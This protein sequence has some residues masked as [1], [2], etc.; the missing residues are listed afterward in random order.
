TPNPF[1]NATYMATRPFAILAF[2]W[3]IKLLPIYE[4][5]KV[6]IKDYVLFSVFLLLTTMTKPSF[7]IIMVGAAGLIMVYRM[8]RSRFKNFWPTR[9]LGVCFIPT[10]IDLLY[11]YSGVFVPTDGAEGGIGFGFADVWSLYSDNIPLAI[12]LA[13]GFPL[14]VLILNWKE[15]KTNVTFRFSWQ[16]YGMSLAMALLLYEK[17]FRQPDFNFSWGYM[18]GIFFAFYGALVVLLQATACKDSKKWKLALQWLA[19]LWH[20]VCGLYYFYG[21][22]NGAMYY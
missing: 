20:V 21:I 15:L 18:H 17:G 7:T 12:G 19:Y 8:I 11:Q 13:A 9:W 22:A 4:T 2:L 10:F 14:L 1:H 16:L 6:A 5:E 3:Y